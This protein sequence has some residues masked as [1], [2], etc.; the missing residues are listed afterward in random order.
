[1]KAIEY[2]N[3][4]NQETDKYTILYQ[5][6]CFSYF[7]SF[8]FNPT[9]EEYVILFVA[10]I[11]AYFQT[12]DCDLGKLADSIAEKYANKKFTLNEF[13]RM[14]KWEVLDLYN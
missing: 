6:F 10:I 9:E 3:I 4:L 5:L 7:Y 14:S 8:V 1:M 11:N 13:N 12:D 2:Y